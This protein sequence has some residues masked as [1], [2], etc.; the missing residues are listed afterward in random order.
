MLHAGL[1]AHCKKGAGEKNKVTKAPSR[2]NLFSTRKSFIL[3]VMGLHKWIVKFRF[4]I[5]LQIFERK[6][7]TDQMMYP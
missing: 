7:N 3:R 1:L 2:V 5:L 6:A 4:Y